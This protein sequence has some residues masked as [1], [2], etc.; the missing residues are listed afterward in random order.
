MGPL[1]S[2]KFLWRYDRM[3]FSV[4]LLHIVG[5]VLVVWYLTNPMERSGGV[6]LI[7]VLLILF[8]KL[9]MVIRR[10]EPD[11]PKQV[12]EKMLRDI[13]DGDGPGRESS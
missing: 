10:L 8:T 7:G 2:I 9:V 3:G 11:V 13:Q 12:A 5:A 4:W 6:L 1:K